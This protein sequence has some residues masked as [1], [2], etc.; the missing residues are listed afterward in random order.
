MSHNC[1]E[2]I[3]E[4]MAEHN[5]AL[6]LHLRMNFETGIA[7]HALCMPLRKINSKLRK[8]LPLLICSYCPACGQKLEA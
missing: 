1:F 3:N 2:Q 6:D 8:P 5:A 4:Q 7:S